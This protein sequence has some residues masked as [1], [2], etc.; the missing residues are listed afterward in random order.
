MKP[1]IMLGGAALALTLVGIAL[2]MDRSTNEG[3]N[4]V[5]AR[6][7]GLS[8]YQATGIEVGV[9][10]FPASPRV[11]DNRLVVAVRERNG[12]PVADLAIA[13]FAEMPAMG[14]MAAMRAPVDLVQVAPGRY[15]GTMKLSMRGEWP[16]TLTIDYP[17][18]GEAQRLKFDLATD[19]AGLGIAAG[20]S[21]VDA[22]AAPVEV[23]NASTNT[24]VNAITID[25]RRRQL[26][27][28]ETGEVSHRDLVKI[29]R[30]VGEVT[31]DERRL[32]QVTLK[33]DGYIG[34][35]AADHVGMPIDK[36]QLLFTVYSPE[37][38]A[39]QREFL[40][41]L[42]RGRDGNA[43]DPV[44]RAARERLRLWD[45]AEAEIEALARGGKP[46]AYL[47]IHAPRGGT[48]VERNIVAGSAAAA[49]Q[50]LLTIVDLSTVWVDAKVYE[51]D[52]EL[53]RVGMAATI[54]LPHVPGR[55]YQA[56]VDHIYPYLHGA[57]RTGRVRLSLA[58]PEGALK[59]QM[60]A[61]V[62][63]RADLGH[64]L[65]VPEEAVI[66][67]GDSRVVFVDLGDGRLNPVRVTLGRRA[68]GHVEVLDGLSLGDRVVTSGNFLLAAETRLKTG[69]QQW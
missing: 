30:A 42:R 69:I 36:G 67:A 33:F 45:L 1:R 26:I 60:Y 13:A 32:S 51:A 44:I 48:L 50:A 25:N 68:Q 57:S 34:D 12:E 53:L 15:E 3:D 10:T 5:S 19:R 55:T 28:V 58:N 35:L 18:G 2:F 41:T 37:L 14:A 62:A 9:A 29:I 16:L 49:G 66:V 31:Y 61:E 20:G 38:L 21:P 8:W 27:G 64:R 59:P 17:A 46:R 56:T 23:A 24:N 11:G 43:D 63:L 22:P 54:T 4:A 6:D 7:A 52:L 39:A 65:A 40:E 47:P